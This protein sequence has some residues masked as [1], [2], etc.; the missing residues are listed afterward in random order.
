MM[1]K[2]IVKLVLDAIKDAIK[3]VYFFSLSCGEIT[4]RAT[5]FYII[6]IT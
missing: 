5:Q 2:Y 3:H 1:A 4:T 6:V